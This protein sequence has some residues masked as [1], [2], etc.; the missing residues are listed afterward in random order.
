MPLPMFSLLATVLLLGVLPLPQSAAAPRVPG[1]E[2]LTVSAP[3]MLASFAPPPLSASG[4]IL[5]DIAS[6]QEVFALHADTSRPMASLTKIMTAL[7]LVEHHSLQDTVIV[8]SIVDTVHGSRLH[9]RP[10]EQFALRDLLEAMLLPSANDIAYALA[11]FDAKT[12]AAF[13]Q[14]MNDRAKSLGLTHTHFMNPAGLD[15]AGQYA[16]PRDVASLAIAAIRHPVLQHMVQTRQASIANT[17]GKTYDLKNT[18]AILHSQPNVFGIKTG[19]T[20]GAGECLVVLFTEGRRS[21]VLVLLGSGDRYT[22]A[23]H[24]MRA[25]HSAMM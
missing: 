7:L 11:V 1:A 25:V 16:S 24:V 5:V 19:T 13:V 14:Q 8:P 21:F 2:T 17:G 18:N 12:V 15:Q 23:L 4:V 9:V 10:G 6:G 20:Q 3:S 22:D